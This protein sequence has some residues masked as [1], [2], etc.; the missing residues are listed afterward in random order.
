[1]GT[2]KIELPLETVAVM[3][4]TGLTE[5]LD[6]STTTSKSQ[7][8]AYTPK[9]ELPLKTV[10]TTMATDLT[11][12]QQDNALEITGN[13]TIQVSSGPDKKT[14][15][16]ATAPGYTLSC[17]EDA[18]D[19]QCWATHFQRN[20]TIERALRG[21]PEP[22]RLENAAASAFRNQESIERQQLANLRYQ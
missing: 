14:T 4:S 20:Q 18:A 6:T 16:L 15:L 10:A 13:S 8:N 7:N 21:L 3:M 1:M 22:S 12:A 17:H 11:E 19:K 9:I 2:P 5:L